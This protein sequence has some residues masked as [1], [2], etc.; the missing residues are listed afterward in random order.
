MEVAMRRIPMSF[1]RGMLC[2]LCLGLLLVACQNEAVNPVSPTAGKDVTTPLYKANQRSISEFLSTQGDPTYWVG[3]D[4]AFYY[5][6]DYAGEL[7]RAYGLNLGT[8]FSGSV[9][10]RPLSDGTAEIT[11]DVRSH[12]ALTWMGRF[13]PPFPIVLG[14][15]PFEVAGGA[16]PT[17]G[18]V[19]FKWVL[20]IPAPGA[21]IPDLFAGFASTTKIQMEASAFGPLTAAAEMGPD[22]TPGHGWTNQVG[23]LTKS[24]GKPGIDGFTAEF[25]KLQRVGH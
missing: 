16:T 23:L 17:L 3:P 13:S 11:I 2:I 14:K 24:H 15:D 8:T 10:E 25:V 22:G 18:D 19:H 5:F 7:D 1:L 12:N 4:L 6:V 21:P 9:T 20:I